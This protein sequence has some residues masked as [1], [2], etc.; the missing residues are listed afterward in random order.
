MF[1]KVCDR[2]DAK[3]VEILT[4]ASATKEFLLGDVPAITIAQATGAFGLSQ[5]ITVDEADKIVMP[6]GRRLLVAIGPPDLARMI[7]DDDVDA[8]NEM[9]VREARDYVVHRP[10]ANFAAEI[11]ARRP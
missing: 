4:P 10:A 9:Q 5:G 11:A 1:E 8:Y 2:F 3:G 6:L 7:A